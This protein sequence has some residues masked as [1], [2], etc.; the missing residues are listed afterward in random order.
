MIHRRTKIVATLGPATDDPAVLRELIVA[1]V[2]VVRLN[3]SHGTRDDH[4]KRADMVREISG[5]LG[6]DVAILGDLQG[7][8]I[9]VE[10]FKDGPVELADGAEF[11]LDTA[12][13]KHEGDQNIVGLAYKELPADV[14]AGSVL[15]LND[16]LIMLTVKKVEGTK[17]ITEVTIGGTLSDR[18]GINKQGGGLS[19]AALT[20]KDKNDIQTAADLEF[21]YL[22]V[23][24]PKN[25]QDMMEARELLEIAGGRASLVA[26]VERAEAVDNL[27]EIIEASD[28]IMVARGD[29]AVEVGDAVLPGLQKQMIHD[30]RERNR[31]VITATQMM[32]SMITNPVPTRAEV[33][34]VANAVI[35]GTDA[36]MLSAETASGKYPVKAVL[37]MDR[38]CKAAESHSMTTRSDHRIDED[39]E[40]VDEAIAMA[41]MYT[42]NH[43]HVKAIVSF[44]ESGYTGLWMS[45]IRSGIPIFAFTRQP[46]TRR[47]VCL[48]RGVYPVPFDIIDREPADI[49]SD[50]TDTLI[51]MKVVEPGDLVVFTK[52]DFDGIAGGTNTMRVHRVERPKEKV[53]DQSGDLDFGDSGA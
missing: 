11:T 43:L 34:D 49:L 47:R 31:C 30:A 9:R 3:F 37:A 18:K 41:T 5:E 45:R 35:D 32:E 12:H 4:A 15:M 13:P 50:A 24:F 28:A 2:N 29:L 1:G 53:G 14:S 27:A 46:A 10:C 6:I 17:I 39:F 19:A 26:K 16:G 21:D 22:A 23:S 52:G 40:R 51:Y 20:D 33:S 48:Y 38:V 8:K 42:A 44:T 7:P 36:V 25:A